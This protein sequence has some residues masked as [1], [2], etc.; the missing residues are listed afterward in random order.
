M[1]LSKPATNINIDDNE[2][3]VCFEIKLDKST[4]PLTF[5][6]SFCPKCHKGTCLP[7]V[8]K[9]LRICCHKTDCEAVLWKCPMCRFKVKVANGIQLVAIERGSWKAVK[10]LKYDDEEEGQHINAERAR[11]LMLSPN[12]PRQ[13][14][15]DFLAGQ[16]P[17]PQILV[18]DR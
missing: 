10:N 3:P 8:K 4:K 7:C 11:E 16:G 17:M 18:A 15:N 6:G 1:A 5:N 14:F 13:E 2:C 12:F 9:L